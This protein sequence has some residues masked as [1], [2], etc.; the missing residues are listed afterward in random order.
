MTPPITSPAG[1]PTPLLI[2]QAQALLRRNALRQAQAGGNG[3]RTR[4][5]VPGVKIGENMGGKLWK[6]SKEVH[7]VKSMTFDTFNDYIL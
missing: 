3:T 2:R 4:G 6:S 5:Q 7:D 1:A